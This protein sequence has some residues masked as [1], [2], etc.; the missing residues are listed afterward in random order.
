MNNYII[1]SND[2]I[3]LEEKIN[4]LNKDNSNEVVYYDLLEVNIERLIEDLD[5]INFLVSKKIIV[6]TNATFL[7][8]DKTKG[9]EHN[10][11]LLEKYLSNPSPDNILILVT[12]NLDKRKKIVN[13]IVEKCNVIEELTDIDS[14]IK[15]HLTDYK[16]DNKSIELLKKYCSNNNERIINEIEKL[17]LYKYDT[18]EI[19]SNDIKDIVTE[20]LDNNI[21]HFVDSILDGNKEYAFRLYHNFLL[22]GETVVKM[23]A[24][25]SN[26]IRLIYQV[27]TLSNLTDKDISKMLKIHEYPIKLAREKSYKYT[28]K[29]LLDDLYKLS[30]L[31]LAIKSGTS[32]GE[33]EF[34]TLLAKI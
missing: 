13:S 21:F 33:V 27:K 6:G 11:D 9:I 5:T 30:E 2:K 32:T 7:S 23:I 34:E 8:T 19:N 14:I 15:K 10:I 18:K 1:V 20:D 24:L 16:I 26:K 4:E 12:D 29:Q 17:K 25:L 22:N 28:E 31:D 3:T